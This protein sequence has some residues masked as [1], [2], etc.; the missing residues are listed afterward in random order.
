MN[1]NKKDMQLNK[2]KWK[3]NENMIRWKDNV[4]MIKNNKDGER[5]KLKKR[6]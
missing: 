3:V 2:K 6:I 5:K 4:N 1:K